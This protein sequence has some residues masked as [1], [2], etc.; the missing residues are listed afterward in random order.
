MVRNFRGEFVNSPPHS[1]GRLIFLPRERSHWTKTDG[2]TNS[3]QKLRTILSS[4]IFLFQ[5]KSNRASDE[6]SLSLS[7]GQ[8]KIQSGVTGAT[9]SIVERET[10]RHKRTMPLG[11]DTFPQY[12]LAKFV[13][14][15]PD[16][17]ALR[18]Y[19]ERVF[20]LPVFLD[21]FD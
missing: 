5:S 11:R 2:S 7:L 4:A 8:R 13:L 16:E 9:V 15:S 10:F 17:T 3:A 1:M 18:N 19:E 14:A 21:T 6:I 12:G 20:F